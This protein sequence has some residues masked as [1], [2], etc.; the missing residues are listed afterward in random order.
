MNRKRTAQGAVQAEAKESHLHWIIAQHSLE[1][2]LVQARRERIGSFLTVEK[3]RY[4][5]TD[6][7]RDD[8]G[9]LIAVLDVVDA[10]GEVQV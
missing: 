2:Q 5:M 4:R 7:F 8:L 1:E 9:R 6:V 10:G 3:R